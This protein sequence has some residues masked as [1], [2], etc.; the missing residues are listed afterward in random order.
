MFDIRTVIKTV[1]ATALIAGVFCT[2]GC[3]YEKLK[4]DN[5]MLIEQKNN[6]DKKVKSLESTCLRMR[7]QLS[8]KDAAVKAKQGQLLAMTQRNQQLGSSIEDLKAK[9]IKLANK[10]GIVI[11]DG[12]LPEGL[13]KELKAFAKANSSIADFDESNGMVKLKSDLTFPPGR[14]KVKEEA[15]SVLAKLAEIL[16]SESAAKF[17]LYIAGHTDDMPISRPSTKRRHPSNWYLSVHRAVGVQEALS[18]AGLDDARMCVLGFSKYHPVTPNKANKG[19]HQANRRVE[20]WIVPSGA[21]V[22]GDVLQ[23]PKVEKKDVPL[24]S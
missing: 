8:E 23:L 5:R 13:S 15:V 1:S 3:D 12:V 4:A 6:S 9:I 10:P 17:S 20:L 16:G 22:A 24:G 2:G 21:F 19:G 7:T 11:R 14:A 18:K